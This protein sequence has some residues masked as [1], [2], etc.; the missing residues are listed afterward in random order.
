MAN[1]KALA[2]LSFNSTTAIRR[3]LDMAIEW[4]WLIG[5]ALVAFVFNGNNY[6][7]FFTQ[8]KQYATH[9]LGLTIAALWLF[10][11]AFAWKGKSKSATE[12]EIPFWKRPWKWAGRNPAR[13]ALIFAALFLFG[14]VMST[15][16][17]QQPLTSFLGRD[18]NDPGY[19]LYAVLAYLLVFSAIA[20]RIHNRAQVMRL[21]IV[22]STVGTLTSAYGLMQSIGID[23]FGFG[24]SLAFGGFRVY[25]TYGNPIFFGSFVLLSLCITFSWLLLNIVNSRELVR[26]PGIGKVSRWYLIAVILVFIVVQSLGIWITASRG[27]TWGLLFGAVPAIVI[28][29]FF[30]L[31]RRDFIVFILAPGFVAGLSILAFVLLSGTSLRGLQGLTD[32]FTGNT[33]LTSL[34]TGRNLIW[35]AAFELLQTREN[36]P[37]ESSVILVPRHVFGYGQ[38]MYY[39]A[40][41]LNIHIQSSFQPASHA[42]SFPLQIVLELGL[43]GGL[44]FAA[45]SAALLLVMIKIS[46][47]AFRYKKASG[48]Y[49][50]GL[51]AIGLWGMLAARLVEQVPGVGRISDLLL[52]W[53]LLG[54]IIAVDRLTSTES[55]KPIYLDEESS[56]KN[57]SQAIRR[58]SGKKR[59]RGIGQRRNVPVSGG[60]VY[61][62]LL[63]IAATVFAISALV[64][65][66]S[67][68]ARLIQG[69]ALAV[70]SI[71]MLSNG[72]N[73]GL[74]LLQNAINLDPRSEEYTR[75]Y[76]RLLSRYARTQEQEA[77]N[78]EDMEQRSSHI[79]NATTALELARNASIRQNSHIPNSYNTRLERVTVLSAYYQLETGKAEAGDEQAAEKAAELKAELVSLMEDM[80]KHLSSYLSVMR[81]ILQA[82]IVL[83]EREDA[84]RIVT[85]ILDN[86]E[87]NQN[88]REAVVRAQILRNLGRVEEYRTAYRYAI[89]LGGKN[90]AN[91]RNENTRM[92]IN[93][94]LAVI[95][96]D[97]ARLLEADEVLDEALI[98]YEKATV[99]GLSQST[100]TLAE[101]RLHDLIGRPLVE[102]VKAPYTSTEA[103]QLVLAYND[104]NNFQ[105]ESSNSLQKIDAFIDDLNSIISS[106]TIHEYKTLA[107]N[108]RNTLQESQTRITDI[109]D[110]R[111]EDN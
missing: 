28:A 14:Q 39:F 80:E 5:L 50:A 97:F 17:S 69:S 101:V 34:T 30:I 100:G 88:I 62:P 61:R 107:I 20:I 96:Y 51:L 18:P 79:N 77:Q 25:S 111:L 55:V 68:D 87:G 2:A 8:P 57:I 63:L 35:G 24:E 108:V 7:F 75:R 53:M 91:A 98:N 106:D 38:E 90:A 103:I 72:D 92:E 46:R 54:L 85:Y 58:L 15:L 94:L 84:L 52:F 109:S 23:P 49:W 78:T 73:D 56:Q 64:V 1:G 9:L 32:I 11:I 66:I 16:F 40:H 99:L 3:K 82:Y 83:E 110:Q 59:K 102:N 36:W 104:F 105:N 86:T 48:D 76:T 12:N 42:H 26:I 81:T 45:L 71:N 37:P 21:I 33:N 22:I 47:A 27:P 19:E 10:D 29:S 60:Y 4:T 95:H 89:D 70:R 43:W 41:P 67:V 6:L 93:N 31:R 65:F 44:S 74:S 13:W